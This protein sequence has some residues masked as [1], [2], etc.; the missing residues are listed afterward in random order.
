VKSGG[1]VQLSVIF[2]AFRGAASDENTPALND[3][4]RAATEKKLVLTQSV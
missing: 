2:F 4:A 1:D 3:L